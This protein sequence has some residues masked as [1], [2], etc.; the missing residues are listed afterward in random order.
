MQLVSVSISGASHNRPRSTTTAPQGPNFRVAE[1][2]RTTIDKHPYEVSFEG[3]IRSNDC[4]GIIVSREWVLTSATCILRRDSKTWVRSGT[5][6]R[7]QHGMTHKIVSVKIHENHDQAHHKNNIA[8]VKVDE[9]FR[10]DQIVML[11][12]N[13]EH[14]DIGVKGI[15]SGYGK[16]NKNEDGRRLH[17]IEVS[18]IDPD[19]C[20]VPGRKR[21]YNNEFCAEHTDRGRSLCSGDDGAPMIGHGFGPVQDVLLGLVSIRSGHSC[22][23]RKADL[24][25]DVGYY[26]EW[27]DGITG[28]RKSDG[29]DEHK[30]KDCD[31]RDKNHDCVDPNNRN[32][33]PDHVDP[34][35]RAKH[36]DDDESCDD[37]CDWLYWLG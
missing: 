23:S 16:N 25:I 20:D 28:G 7:R 22:D 11:P 3:E 29:S 19:D 14:I 32:K 10:D 24:F 26:R 15:I 37:L 31:H 1:G 30:P 9:P 2:N 35:R 12:A 27:I 36:H 4:A 18:V 17:A 33:H 6:F 13:R 8:L 21:V 5:S 34:G